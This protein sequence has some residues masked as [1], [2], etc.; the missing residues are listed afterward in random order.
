MA[1]D[2]SKARAASLTSFATFGRTRCDGQFAGLDARDFEEVRCQL[3]Q[4]V[5]LL[6]DDL[7]EL[8]HFLGIGLGGRAQHGRGG[9]LNRGQRR[10]Q[11]AAHHSQEFGSLALNLFQRRHVL[12]GGDDGDNLAFLRADWLGVDQNAH[13]LPIGMLDDQLLRS[14]GGAAAQGAG[15]RQLVE[16]ELMP[17]RVAEGH[18]AEQGLQRVAAPAHASHDASRLLVDG[19]EVA[20]SRVEHENAER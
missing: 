1:S 15:Q 9:T 19:Q 4:P 2:C 7:E 8:Q 20:G 17:I 14:H 13:R 6:V 11:A 16:V 18:H 10:A 5:G 3:A 12:D